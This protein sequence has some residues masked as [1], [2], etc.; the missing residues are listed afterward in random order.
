M[1]TIPQIEAL[2]QTNP[3]LYETLNRLAAASLGPGEPQRVVV[4]DARRSKDAVQQDVLAAV[5]QRL[6][7]EQG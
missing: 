1:L 3:Q 5:R 2:R 6:M 4:I 7:A